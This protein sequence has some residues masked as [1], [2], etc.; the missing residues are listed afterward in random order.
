LDIANMPLGADMKSIA[1]VAALLVLAITVI[2]EGERL[3][4]PT[5]PPPVIHQE[6]FLLIFPTAGPTSGTDVLKSRLRDGWRIAKVSPMGGGDG[7]NY[8]SLVVLERSG[9]VPADDSAAEPHAQE[10]PVLSHLPEQRS[11]VQ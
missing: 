1:I 2:I 10:P 8:V 4:R 6:P 11:A 7:H 5:P 3:R 9:D